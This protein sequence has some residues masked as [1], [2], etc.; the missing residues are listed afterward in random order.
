MCGMAVGIK[1]YA[2]PR[3]VA[4]NFITIEKLLYSSLNIGW[5]IN[6]TSEWKKYLT[7]TSRGL[8]L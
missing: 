3:I 6:S 7:A 8:L 5:Y 1:Q 2:Q 4:L